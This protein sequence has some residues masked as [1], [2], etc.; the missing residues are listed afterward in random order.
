MGMSRVMY[1]RA[2]THRESRGRGLS[3]VVLAPAL[4]RDFLSF[5]RL[6]A[7]GQTIAR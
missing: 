6:Q 7:P 2:C 3:L 1:P 4:L 5:S